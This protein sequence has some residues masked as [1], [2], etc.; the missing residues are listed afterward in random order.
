MNTISLYYNKT[1]IKSMPNIL[2][3]PVQLLMKLTQKPSLE[4][5]SCLANRIPTNSRKSIKLLYVT[6]S[7]P[8]NMFSAEHVCR[9]IANATDFFT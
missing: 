3:V 1:C 4:I 9:K 8:N 7:A 6:C 5:S 2:L